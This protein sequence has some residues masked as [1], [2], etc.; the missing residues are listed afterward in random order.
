MKFTKPVAPT[1]ADLCTW[2]SIRL[3]HSLPHK[4]PAGIAELLDAVVAAGA[5]EVDWDDEQEDV[6][7][8]VGSHLEGEEE[9]VG[10][11][12]DAGHDGAVQEEKMYS[13]MR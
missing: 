9:R 10:D 1:S 3:G 12:Q 7:D 6:F 13:G 5:Q 4:D 8:P 11:R 2:T